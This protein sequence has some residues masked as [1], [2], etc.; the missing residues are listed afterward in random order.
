M[1]IAVTIPSRRRSL[2]VISRQ[3]NRLIASSNGTICRIDNGDGGVR[4]VGGGIIDFFVVTVTADVT[5]VIPS[6]GVTG[7]AGEHVARA[8]APEQVT[9]TA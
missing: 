9:V 8:G 4:K 2:R 7:D 6:A 1:T 5:A 3:T